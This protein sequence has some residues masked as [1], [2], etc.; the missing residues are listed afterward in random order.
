MGHFG[1]SNCRRTAAAMGQNREVTEDALYT[2]QMVSPNRL[3]ALSTVS[4]GKMCSAFV[5]MV[6]VT[7][8]CMRQA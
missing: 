1:S 2:R 6:L 8:T 3:A 5:G 7:M 4:S